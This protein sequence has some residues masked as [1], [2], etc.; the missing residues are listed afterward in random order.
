MTFKIDQCKTQER[1][2]SISENF[3]QKYPAEHRMH[4]ILANV[5]LQCTRL[6]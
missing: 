4:V 3:I 6:E 5:L 2:Y 1:Y